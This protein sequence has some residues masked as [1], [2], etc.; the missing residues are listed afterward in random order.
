VDF[1]GFLEFRAAPLLLA[2][3]RLVLTLAQGDAGPDML[4][5]SLLVAMASA[6][7]VAGPALCL[8]SRVGL[9]SSLRNLVLIA[10]GAYATIYTVACLLWLANMLNFWCFLVLFGLSLVRK[11]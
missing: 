9:A 1:R 5:G 11:N 6:A 4:R 3:W 2:P 8:R 7:L 10:W